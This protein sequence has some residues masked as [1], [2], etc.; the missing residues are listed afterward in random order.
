[1]LCWS[2][3]KGPV[4]HPEPPEPAEVQPKQEGTSLPCLHP[5]SFAQLLKLSEPQTRS[6][7][8]PCQASPALS[9]H[10]LNSYKLHTHIHCKQHLLIYP[11][12]NIRGYSM[13]Y[14]CTQTETGRED[15]IL[16]VPTARHH[17]TTFPQRLVD[18]LH[19]LVQGCSLLYIRHAPSPQN[20]LVPA[21]T[22][23]LW[24]ALKKANPN[25]SASLHTPHF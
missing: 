2:S 18:A 1:M 25:L 24:L 6:W 10:H 23:N 21:S 4:S 14:S 20:K 22:G 16:D 8:F 11:M 9:L 12:L 15:E 5:A 19:P 13:C 7:M 3:H 17:Q